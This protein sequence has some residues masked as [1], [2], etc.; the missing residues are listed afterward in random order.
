MI[1]PVI[2]RQEPSSDDGHLLPPESDLVPDALVGDLNIFYAF[3]MP[4]HFQYVTEHDRKTLELDPGSLRQLSVRNLTKRRS[5]PEVMRPSDA[6]WMVR[7]DGDLE[8]S[9][10]L[11]DWLW[12]QLA[13]GVPGETIVAVPNRDILVVSGTEV[14]GGVEALR[15]AVK[16]VWGNPNPN[17]KQLLTRSLLIRRDT[18]WEVFEP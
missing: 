7:L 10:L 3:D 18:R 16:R 4:G 11:V 2:K 13:R 8:A 12:P 1:V 5:K 9:L 17:R 15:G 6:A 14:T